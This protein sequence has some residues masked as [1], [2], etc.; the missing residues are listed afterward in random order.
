MAGCTISE[1]N[2]VMDMMTMQIEALRAW[3]LLDLMWE[4]NNAVSLLDEIKKDIAELPDLIPQSR[5]L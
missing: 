3:T 5:V 1:W 2:I 4:E